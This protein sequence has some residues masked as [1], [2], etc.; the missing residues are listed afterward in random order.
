MTSTRPG[1]MNGSAARSSW[2]MASSRSVTVV[3]VGGRDRARGG[4]AS[5]SYAGRS[6]RDRRD[7]RDRAGEPDERARLAAAGPSRRPASSAASMSAAGRGDLRRGRRVVV[8]VPLGH[9][10]AADVDRAGRRAPRSVAEDELGRAAAD[11]DDEVRLR[12][13]LAA[14]SSRV[15]PAKDS[16]ASSSPVIDLGLDAEDLARRRRRTRRGS[17]RRGSPRS[18]RSAR[19][20]RRC[21]RDRPRRTSRSAAK[22]RSSASGASRPVRSTP[23]PSRTISIRRSTSASVAGVGSTSATSSRI[24][25]VPQ[26]IGG[27][28]ASRRLARR[29]DVDARPAAPPV[30]A[31][32]RAPRRRA[33]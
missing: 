30:A 14:A 6:E 18:R 5:G 32:R 1:C 4:C 29:S 23:W 11:V 8:Q 2:V 7:R 15:A 10:D 28:P 33:G 9:A 25:L 26:S 24:E 20:R 19:A 12:R 3:H 22:V 16:S 17:R 31:A 13:S 21:S 27:D